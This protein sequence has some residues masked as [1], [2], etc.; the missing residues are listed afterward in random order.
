MVCTGRCG[1]SQNTMISFQP[2]SKNRYGSGQSGYSARPTRKRVP[3]ARQQNRSSE[4]VLKAVS[5]PASAQ[6]LGYARAKPLQRGCSNTRDQS[7][8]KQL[9][10]AIA[11]PARSRKWPPNSS[12]AKRHKRAYGFVSRGESDVCKSITKRAYTKKKPARWHVRKLALKPGPP[13][14]KSKLTWE[15]QYF[16]TVTV[17]SA[18]AL[19]TKPDICRLPRVPALPLHC[20]R[21]NLGV[22]WIPDCQ[23]GL[24]E[25]FPENARVDNRRCQPYLSVDFPS[26]VE[27]K[28]SYFRL[29]QIYCDPLW[30][31]EGRTSYVQVPDNVCGA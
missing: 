11:R 26:M 28:C 31:G 9:I 20:E 23:S 8:L 6:I 12:L 3:P 13:T 19:K 21:I 18:S 7:R 15:R 27:G 16:G 10:S 29:R 4:R 22:T 14:V 2:L 25:V 30:V 17:G 5:D 1:K 24:L